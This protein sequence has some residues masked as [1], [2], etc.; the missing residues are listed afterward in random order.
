MLINKNNFLMIKIKN[1]LKLTL[2][3]FIYSMLNYKIRHILKINK[4]K[5]SQILPIILSKY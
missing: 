2:L 1:N 3:S 5:I 4:I